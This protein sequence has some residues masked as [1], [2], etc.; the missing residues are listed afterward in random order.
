[1]PNDSTCRRYHAVAAANLQRALAQCKYEIIFYEYC[2]YFA[3]RKF[4]AIRYPLK[5]KMS[6]PV[7]VLQ[8]PFSKLKV[9][10][11]ILCTERR[12]KVWSSY[13]LTAL[14]KEGH[15]IQRGFTCRRISRYFTLLFQVDVTGESSYCFMFTI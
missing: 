14:L 8:K 7:S 6:F 11:H 4:G 15:S 1:M 10:D 12:L 13:Y 3:L 5:A 2:K 9:S